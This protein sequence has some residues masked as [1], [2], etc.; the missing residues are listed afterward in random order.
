MNTRC[1]YIVRL[2]FLAACCFGSFGR[3]D[4]VGDS[5]VQVTFYAMG[6]VP[7]APGED[8]LLPKQI[9]N[10]PGD[11]EFVIHVGDIK[12]GAP[13]CTEGVYQ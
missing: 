13:L 1:F 12:R 9:A 6:D 2:L 5:D 7:Y 3:A 8:V 4:A 10:L 11:A